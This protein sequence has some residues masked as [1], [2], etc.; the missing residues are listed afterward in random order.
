MEEEDGF[1]EGECV[2]EVFEILGD[3]FMAEFV[4]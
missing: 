2:G 3:V 1:F 4:W